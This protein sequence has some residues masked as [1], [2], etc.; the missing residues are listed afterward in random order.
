[1]NNT[2]QKINHTRANAGKSDNNITIQDG[3]RGCFVLKEKIYG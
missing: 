2:R 1:M 3:S